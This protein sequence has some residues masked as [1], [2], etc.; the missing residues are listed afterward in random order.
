ME[1]VNPLA[2][3]RTISQILSPDDFIQEMKAKHIIN[4]PKDTYGKT[5]KGLCRISTTW[6]IQRLKR[7]GLDTH[8]IVA[9]GYYRGRPTCWL[10]FGD[11]FFDLTLAQFVEN[12]PQLSIMKRENGEKAHIYSIGRTVPAR[13]WVAELDEKTSPFANFIREIKEFSTAKLTF[14]F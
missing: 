10:I 4:K 13:E 2:L 6:M 9:E 7:W 3:D 1:F 5:V 12:A 14:H 8:A 11:H